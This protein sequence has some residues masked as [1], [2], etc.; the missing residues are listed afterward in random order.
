MTDGLTAGWAVGRKTDILACRGRSAPLRGAAVAA[1]GRIDQNANRSAGPPMPR[2]PDRR[3]PAAEF[4]ARPSAMRQ[5]VR[6][7]PIRRRPR[8]TSILQR[9]ESR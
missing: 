3:L 6:L 5:A 4:D 2:L 1:G 8:G 7:A 9:T